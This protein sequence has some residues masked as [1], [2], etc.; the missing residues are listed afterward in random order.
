MTG[1][2]F[3]VGDYSATAPGRDATSST[4]RSSAAESSSSIAHSRLCASTEA[5]IWS[6]SVRFSSA[7]AALPAPWLAFHRALGFNRPFGAARAER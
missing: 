4:T 1:R 7:A 2:R 6:S 5:R 3:N